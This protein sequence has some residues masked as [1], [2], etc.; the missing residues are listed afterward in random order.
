[1]FNKYKQ[2]ENK[3]KELEN[4][5]VEFMKHIIGV[6]ETIINSSK[7]KYVWEL[8]EEEVS[9]IIEGKKLKKIRK[10]LE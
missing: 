9:D 2:L 7:Q 10:I 1:M 4:G 3:I 8:R 6:L 5:Q